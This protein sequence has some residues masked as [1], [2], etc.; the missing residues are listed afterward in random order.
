MFV[1]VTEA[2]TT[3]RCRGRAVDQTSGSVALILEMCTFNS[4]LS[5]AVCL[6]HRGRDIG[7]AGGGLGPP[8]FQIGGAQPPPL[9]LLVVQRNTISSRLFLLLKNPTSG[10]TDSANKALF[11][12]SSSKQR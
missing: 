7:G 4:H 1:T 3:I 6:L 9:F 12:S 8:T 2:E 5:I 11:P 10:E